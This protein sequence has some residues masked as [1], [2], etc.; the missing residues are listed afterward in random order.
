MSCKNTKQEVCNTAQIAG[1]AVAT[2]MC[3]GM[4]SEFRL[5]LDWT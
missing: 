2:L 1:L 4:C 3:G 5:G